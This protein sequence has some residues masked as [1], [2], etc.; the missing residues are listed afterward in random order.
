M[1]LR[2]V[3]YY[4]RTKQRLL[5]FTLHYLTGQLDERVHAK[6]SAT[7]YHMNRLLP[8]PAWK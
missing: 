5:L 2:L 6:S 3:Q 1:S 7:R 8:A 4:F